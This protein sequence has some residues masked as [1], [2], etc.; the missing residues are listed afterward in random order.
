M[1]KI[2]IIISQEYRNR[3][4]KKSFILLTFLMPLL[5]AAVIFVP[6]W[7]ASIDSDEERTVVV[8]DQTGLYAD[9][10]GGLKTDVCSFDVVR[11]VTPADTDPAN[12]RGKETMVLLVSGDLKTNPSAIALYS[13]KQVLT[14]CGAI[15][16]PR[17]RTTSSVRSS[18]TTTFPASSR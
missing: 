16:K 11:E 9:F 3:V 17:C 14:R 5:M 4:A 15:S 2:G 1:S 12:Y 7:L 6:V 10:F 13:D 18:T 8:V